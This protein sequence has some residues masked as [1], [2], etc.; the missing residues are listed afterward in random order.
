MNKQ[1]LA[2]LL[3]NLAAPAMTAKVVLRLSKERCPSLGRAVFT[4]V[5]SCDVHCAVT[6]VLFK[7]IFRIVTLRRPGGRRVRALFGV[8][9]YQLSSQYR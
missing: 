7:L 2:P 6:A 5:D 4:G 3:V 8:L 1:K 9:R